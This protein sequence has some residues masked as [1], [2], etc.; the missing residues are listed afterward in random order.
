[1]A[2]MPFAHDE[3]RRAFADQGTARTFRCLQTSTTTPTDFRVTLKYLNKGAANVIFQIHA[4]QHASSAT[5]FLFAELRQED[6][7]S[8]MATPLHRQHFM[9]RV[10]R[11]PR[12]GAKHLTSTEIIHGFEHAIRPL[13]LPGTYETVGNLDVPSTS[14]VQLTQDLTKHLM[15]HEGVLLLPEVMQHLYNSAETGTF[16]STKPRTLW[17]ILLPDMSPIPGQSIT[18]EVKPKWLAQSPNAPSKALRCRTCAMQVSVPKNR[19]AYVCPLQLLHG[20]A[21]ILRP[22]ARTTIA[23]QFPASDRNPSSQTVLAAMTEG[24]LSYL[25]AGEGSTLLRHLLKLQ[26][27]LDPFGVLCRPR[28]SFQGA[29]LFEHNLRLAMTLRDC[30]LFIKMSYSPKGLVSIESKLGDLDFKSAVKMVDWS[31]KERQLLDEGS[32]V[33]KEGPRCWFQTQR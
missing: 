20:N 7:P 13:F 33:V 21:A 15:Y 22:W 24:L 14:T 32:Y 9:H 23:R 28:D 8:Q 27:T 10:V 3:M 31:E 12:G 5:S 25:T 18:L 16:T 4:W 17:G 6:D 30:S 2:V 11:V 26:S 1:M 29:A 19:D